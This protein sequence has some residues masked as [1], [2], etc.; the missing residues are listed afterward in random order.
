M[1]A[2]NDHVFSLRWQTEER[3]L[4]GMEMWVIFLRA[5]RSKQEDILG[6][7]WTAMHDHAIPTA[8]ICFHYKAATRWMRTLYSA[9]AALEDPKDYLSQIGLGWT[10]DSGRPPSCG[11]VGYASEFGAMQIYA[12]WSTP[13]RWAEFS[14]YPPDDPTVRVLLGIESVAHLIQMTDEAFK[15]LGWQIPA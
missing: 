3:C 9:F 11:L 10:I 7:G 15:S 4:S 8:A 12:D 1:K 5:A 2:K 13:E 6:Y 14:I